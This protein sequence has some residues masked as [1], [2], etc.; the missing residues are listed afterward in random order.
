MRIVTH[1]DFDGLISAYLVCKHLNLIDPEI[2]IEEPNDV[3]KG[4]IKFNRT[5]IVCDLPQPRDADEQ[6]VKVELW[7]DH[8]AESNV[9]EAPQ[10][11]LYV[12]SEK[13]CAQVIY[14][15]FKMKG[16]KEMLEQVNRIDSADFTPENIDREDTGFFLSWSLRSKDEEEDLKFFRYV[17][18]R[19]L[20]H[21]YEKVMDEKIMERAALKID[22]MKKSRLRIKKI[23]EIKGDIGILDM[24]G[25]EDSK[26][27]DKFYPFLLHP[28]IKYVIKIQRGPKNKVRIGIAK[29]FLLKEKT[30]VSVQEISALFGGGGHKN[31]GGFDSTFEKLDRDLE[32]LVRELESAIK[33]DQISSKA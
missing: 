18:K 1:T 4:L 16:E 24:R 14:D 25:E 17:L 27:F 22:A 23:M 13:S 33:E 12:P 32:N 28:K 21:G 26:S 30:D 29:N 5:D 3:Q 19:L 11:G 7:F 20:E 10:K 15:Y 31:V 6:A 8:H 9:P 2:A